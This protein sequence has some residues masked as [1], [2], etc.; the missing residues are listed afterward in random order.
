MVATFAQWLAPSHEHE[1]LVATFRP[2]LPSFMPD[3]LERPPRLI[4]A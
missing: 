2:L 3:G 1:V 4:L